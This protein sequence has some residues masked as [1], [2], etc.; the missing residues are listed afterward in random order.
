MIDTQDLPS[1]IPGYDEYCEPKEPILEHDYYDEYR[2]E[3]MIEEEL[4]KTNSENF[5]EMNE[6]E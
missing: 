5:I 2:D 6:G 4:E 1:Y 3:K